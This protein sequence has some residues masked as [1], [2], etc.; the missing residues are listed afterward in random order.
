MFRN[1]FFKK[2]Q[3]WQ[4]KVNSHMWKINERRTFTCVH[5]CTCLCRSCDLGFYIPWIDPRLAVAK[6]YFIFLVFISLIFAG[7]IKSAAFV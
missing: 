4:G 3:F 7:L 5:L 1:Y 2:V 6:D